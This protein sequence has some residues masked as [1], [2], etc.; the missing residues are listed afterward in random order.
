MPTANI[1]LTVTTDPAHDEAGER[2]VAHQFVRLMREQIA[3]VDL[4]EQ[5]VLREAA[6]NVI[7]SLRRDFR[8]EELKAVASAVLAA[9]ADLGHD[10][11]AEA[12]RN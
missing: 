12:A 10:V 1:H 4:E 6:L 3:D 7:A 8:S 9:L 5:T 2:Y 11:W